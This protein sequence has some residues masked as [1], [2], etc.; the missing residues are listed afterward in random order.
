MTTL[1]SRRPRLG[2]LRRL[3]A[4]WAATILLAVPGLSPAAVPLPSRVELTCVDPDATAYGTFQSHNQKVGATWHD[5]AVSEPVANPYA[6]GGCREITPDGSIIGSFTDQLA[7]ASDA[8]GGSKVYFFRIPNGSALPQSPRGSGPPRSSPPGTERAPWLRQDLSAGFGRLAMAGAGFTDRFGGGAWGRLNGAD[9]DGDGDTDIVAS[10]GAG[11]GARGTYSGLFVYEN[12]GTPRKALLGPG[13]QLAAHEQIEAATPFTGDADADGRSDIFCNGWL[14]VTQSRNGAIAFAPPRPAPD[15]GWP[16]PSEC[17]WNGDGLLDRFEEDRWQLRY[18]DGASGESVLLRPGGR[19][20]LIDIFIRPYACDWDGDGDLDVLVGQES[21]HITWVENAGGRLAAERYVMQSGP[22]VDAGCASV[23]ALCDWDG[24]GDTDLIAGSAAGF[25]DYFECQ[26]G[27]FRPVRRLRAGA[28]E[29]RVLAGEL[30]SVQGPGEARW[31]YT[32]PAA[33]DWD[34]DGDLDL[35]CG[36]VTGENL[37]FENIGSRADPRLAPAVRL[38]V[39]WGDRQPVHPAGMRYSPE[40]GGLVTQWRCRPVVLDW[41]GDGLPDYLTVDEKGV[42]AWYRR[43]RG[44]GGALGLRPAEYP[45]RDES[46]APLRF[47]SHPEPGRNGR[48]KF[49]LADWDGDGDLDIIRGAGREDGTQNLDNGANFTYLE[50]VATAGDHRA[51]FRWRGELVP[52]E[53]IRLQGHTAAPVVLDLDGNGTLDILAG[54]EDGNIYW[55]LREWIE[56]Q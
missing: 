45:F 12:I 4:G 9:F 18:T 50:C 49:A 5:H 13:L 2:L 46:L 42:L 11:G 44:D 34:L 35:L 21:G 53:K 1:H 19:E 23:P 25:I 56:R 16:H 31:G 27:E 29:I 30:G 54:C 36:C 32:C 10:Y 28:A 47:C 51:V 17:D 48:I 22:N 38:K 41:D 15:P 24:D 26:D 20:L 8:G 6:I 7:P 43:F 33:A 37:F 52:S 39:D 55:F 14:F 40:P 3:R